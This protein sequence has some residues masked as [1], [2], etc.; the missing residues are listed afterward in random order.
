[1]LKIEPVRVQNVRDKLAKFWAKLGRG[2]KGQK[3]VNIQEKLVV[4]K[5]QCPF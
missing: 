4:P 1:M 2:N 3:W 5:K